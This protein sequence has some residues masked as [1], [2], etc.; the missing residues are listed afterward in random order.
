M[1]S[2][3]RKRHL[4]RRLSS[5]VTSAQVPSEPPGHKET[6]FFFALSIIFKSRQNKGEE[7]GYK[8]FKEE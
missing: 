6:F 2:V 3:Q 1:A 4:S 7:H 5:A 8:I